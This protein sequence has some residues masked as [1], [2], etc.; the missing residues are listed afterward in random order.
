MSTLVAQTISNGTVST[1]SENV[2][3][4]SARAWVNYKGTATQSIRDSFN[5]SSVT[6]NSTGDYTLN[7]TTAMPNANYAINGTTQHSGNFSANV[8]AVGMR[9]SYTPTTTSVRISVNN[10]NPAS[11]DYRDMDYVFVTVFSS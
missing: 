9:D 2:I 5:I 11:G 10:T 4:G 3:R 1:S 7:F 8:T 6:Y